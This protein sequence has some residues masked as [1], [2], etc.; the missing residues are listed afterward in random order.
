MKPTDTF[1]TYEGR[2]IQII[3]RDENGNVRFQYRPDPKEKTMRMNTLLENAPGFGISKT[4][5]NTLKD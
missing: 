2:P 4:I 1:R 5:L 3:W